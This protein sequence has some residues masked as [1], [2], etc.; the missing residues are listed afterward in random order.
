MSGRRA[1]SVVVRTL[2][3]V[4]AL[5]G[6]AAVWAAGASA[7]GQPPAWAS[8]TPAQHEALAPLE[9]DWP[10]LDGW[11]KQK[12]LRVAKRFPQLPQAER[13]RVQERMRVWANMTPAQRGQARLRFQ[14]SRQFSAEDRQARWAAYQALPED[15]RRALAHHARPPAKGSADEP[16]YDSGAKRNMVAP[17]RQGS[18][19]SV[20]PTLVQARPGASTTLVSPRPAQTGH[21][22]PG[23]PKIIATPGFVNPNTLLPRR[24]PQGAAAREAHDTHAASAPAAAR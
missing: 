5:A 7:A 10:H 12:W 4:L 9:H 13:Q 2:M 21:Q 22:Q 23:L 8:L 3:A 20:A 15:R 19:Q 6:A 24:G 11:R 14:Q 1:C 18:T 16:A 17:H